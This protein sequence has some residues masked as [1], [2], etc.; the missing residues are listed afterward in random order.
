[1]SIESIAIVGAGIGGL[2]SAVFL[3][4][5]GYKVTVFDKA[6]EPRPVGAGFL[7]QPPGQE[8][9][10]ELGILDEV[11]GLSVP[12]QG[13][14]SQTA[15]GYKL[16]DLHYNDLKG[17]PRNGLGVQRA[18]IYQALYRLASRCE[19]V[20]FKWG[21]DVE[22]CRV[23]NEQSV[24][25]IHS[26]VYHYDLCILSSGS[27]SHLADSLFPNRIKKPYSWK[28]LWTTVKLPTGFSENILHQRC[29][30]ANKMMG[31]LPVIKT[32]EGYEAVLYW[33]LKDEDAKSFSEPSF[34]S[35]KREIIDFWPEARESIEPLEY[36][37]FIVA[38]YNDLWTPNP[39]N[40]NFVAIGDISHSTSP[41]LG[42][43]CTMALL[44]SQLLAQHLTN[45]RELHESL[46]EWWRSRK[47][48]LMY[49]R[50]VSRLLTP[51]YQ[52]DQTLYGLF[53]NCLVAP[54]GR[55]PWLYQWQLKTLAS[56]IFLK[57]K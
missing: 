54:M 14:K 20:Q 8:V 18:T 55:I 35:V 6:T 38:N 37:D 56:D 21:C 34:L 50:H 17:E 11:V 5:K 45:D 3:S 2:S 53:R 22:K 33:S 16:L 24:I 25:H 51:L 23:E 39:F 9:L 52:S 43:G 28:C 1:M 27:N 30:Q 49:V 31:L 7:L 32:K 40:K 19:G 41:Q 13:L 10:A 36:S 46:E 29:H 57:K 44:D 4:R 12:I 42:Q 48:Q 47:K 15:S 26:D